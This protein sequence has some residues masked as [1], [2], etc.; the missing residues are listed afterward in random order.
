MFLPGESQGRG[1][2]VGCRLWGRTE[3]DTTEVTWQLEFVE[4]MQSCWQYDFSLVRPVSDFWLTEVW[5]KIKSCVALSQQVGDNL[6]QWQHKSST[7][8]IVQLGTGRLRRHTS[9]HVVVKWWRLFT[10]SS[11]LWVS[12]THKPAT[13]SAALWLPPC[14]PPWNPSHS[15]PLKWWWG[16]Y[17]NFAIY[18]DTLDLRKRIY[19]TSLNTRLP[20]PSAISLALKFRLTNTPVVMLLNSLTNIFFETFKP[21]T[22]FLTYISGFFINPGKR[23]L[24]S[25]AKMSYHFLCWISFI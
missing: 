3:S 15:L 18:L 20:R 10:V 8:C 6:L 22:I 2:L 9:V 21:F 25:K 14:P 5:T 1:S 23:W 4:G 12:S 11:L 17:L 7:C 13:K 19:H 16:I 24:F